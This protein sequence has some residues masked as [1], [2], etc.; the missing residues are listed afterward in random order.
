MRSLLSRQQRPAHYAGRTP[1]PV[2]QDGTL[3]TVMTIRW[4]MAA[5]LAGQPEQTLGWCSLASKTVV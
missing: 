3:L 2:R 5:G 4:A 1:K